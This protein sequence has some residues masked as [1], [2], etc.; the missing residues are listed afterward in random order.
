MANIYDKLERQR[1]PRV[2]IKYEIETGGAT[3]EREAAFIHPLRFHRIHRAYF[4][5]MT[6]PEQ[7]I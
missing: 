3:V 7:S 2:H 6:G 4:S 1:R 5:Q